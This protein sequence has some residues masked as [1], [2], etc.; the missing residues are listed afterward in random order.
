MV[1]RIV[2][3]YEKILFP[4]YFVCQAYCTVHLVVVF[5]LITK[6]ETRSFSRCRHN[7]TKEK[8]YES[9]FLVLTELL[10]IWEE[11]SQAGESYLSAWENH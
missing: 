2:C 5:F 1:P 11:I 8:C 4:I 6:L 3:L 9:I 7:I 10:C